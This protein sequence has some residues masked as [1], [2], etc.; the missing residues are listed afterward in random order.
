MTP[1]TR[2]RM[3]DEFGN[4]EIT[5][6][7]RHA[8]SLFLFWPMSLLAKHREAAITDEEAVEK[9]AEFISRWED[10]GLRASLPQPA[11]TPAQ[12]VLVEALHKISNPFDHGHCG[13]CG[14][15]CAGATDCDC[16]FP[17]WEQDN[18]IAIAKAALSQATE[19]GK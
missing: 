1:T 5:A 16:S 13:T 18:P 6:L 9:L 14:K 3:G 19:E 8:A 15:G 17:V 12:S 2:P 10:K 4:V 11:S 7:H